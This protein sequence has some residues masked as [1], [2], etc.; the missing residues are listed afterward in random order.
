MAD[1]ALLE[2]LTG[3]SDVASTRPAP[4]EQAQFVLPVDQAALVPVAEMAMI[5][6]TLSQVHAW[7]RRAGRGTRFL[8]AEADLPDPVPDEVLEAA[9]SEYDQ[10]VDLD[11]YGWHATMS[12]SDGVASNNFMLLG[13]G[14]VGADFPE[15]P[16]MSGPWR[17]PMH[18]RVHGHPSRGCSPST[19]SRLQSRLPAPTASG[20]GQRTSLPS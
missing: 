5:A 3:L 12:S 4:R 15:L 10:R 9:L 13:A 2:T 8:V 7:L 17:D 14:T 1:H 6:V 19:R 16:A 18:V 20:G 11:G